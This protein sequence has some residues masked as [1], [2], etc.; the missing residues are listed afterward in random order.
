MSSVALPRADEA[1]GDDA[2][3]VQISFLADRSRLELSGEV[4]A[5]LNAELARA[6]NLLAERGL[7]VDIETRDLTFVDSSVIALVAH[8]ANRLR[9]RVRFLAPTQQVRF[10][11]D[12][13]QVGELVDV[14]DPEPPASPAEDEAHPAVA[15][16]TAI[17]AE[18]GAAAEAGTDVVDVVRTGSLVTPEDASGA[19]P[20]TA[21]VAL[22]P[23][24]IAAAG[25]G[26]AAS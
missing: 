12:L 16:A 4:D 1:F 26:V 20:A 19:V 18:A 11:L 13:T 14:V 10:L 9:A 7:T 24:E 5:R 2:G 21:P 22:S 25:P 17:A 3:G 6:T 23:D 15:E 8:L